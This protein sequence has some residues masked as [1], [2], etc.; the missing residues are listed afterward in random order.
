V[1]D[2]DRVIVGSGDGAE[3]EK[4]NDARGGPGKEGS[5]VEKGSYG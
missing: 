3:P 1:R 4:N 2:I 5:H